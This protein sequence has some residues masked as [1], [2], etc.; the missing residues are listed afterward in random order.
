MVITEREQQN[1]LMLAK[2]FRNGDVALMECQLVET[3][4]IVP[5]ICAVMRSSA[6]FLRN[7]ESVALEK[8]AE[9]LQRIERQ[10][11]ASNS[12]ISTRSHSLTK[13]NSPSQ[14]AI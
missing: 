12:V 4:E 14:L 6:Y 3:L 2:A 5:V 13:S 9:H 10:V 7:S 8:T 1:F 11:A